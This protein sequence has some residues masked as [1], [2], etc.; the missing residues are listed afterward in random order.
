MRARFVIPIL[1]CVLVLSTSVVV[2]ADAGDINEAVITGD[3]AKVQ[4]LLREDPKLATASDESGRTPL[5]FAAQTGNI[6][7]ISMLLAAGADVKAKCMYGRTPLHVATCARQ[8]DAMKA[9]IAAG[10]EVDAKDNMGKTSLIWAPYEGRPWFYDETAKKCYLEPATVLVEAGAD[11][12]AKDKLGSTPMHYAA[13]FGCKK[14][15]SLL[16]EKKAQIDP[17]NLEGRTPLHQAA[18]RGNAELVRI[19]LDAGARVD[20]RDAEGKTPL[21]LAYAGKADKA[22]VVDVLRA[23]GAK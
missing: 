1:I 3:S 20:V 2:A 16:V 15:A 13:W 7:V 10:A 19:L 4:M 9:L 6:G 17:L 14:I 5:H 22:T 11:V 18:F 23:A 12:N 8:V 21:D